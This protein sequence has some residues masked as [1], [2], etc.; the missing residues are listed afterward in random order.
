MLAAIQIVDHAS[1]HGNSMVVHQLVLKTDFFQSFYS[2][3]RERK[4]YGSAPNMFG[5]SDICNRMVNR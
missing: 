2:T 3:L 1:L 5:F 4:V